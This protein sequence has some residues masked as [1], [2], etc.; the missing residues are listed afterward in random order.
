MGGQF[1]VWSLELGCWVLIAAFL[2]FEFTYP[3]TL[4]YRGCSTY[5]FQFVTLPIRQAGL[6]KIEFHEKKG[7]R[8]DALF[9]DSLGSFI[10][11]QSLH[12]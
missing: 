5:I 11:L 7:N 10:F 12:Q 2:K 6:L 9:L 4:H 3:D 8:C 1:R